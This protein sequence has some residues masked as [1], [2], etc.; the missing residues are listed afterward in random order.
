MRDRIDVAKLKF[1]REKWRLDRADA[2]FTEAN[3]ALALLNSAGAAA[4]LAFMQALVGKA[5]T[6]GEFKA[7]GVIALSLFLIGALSAAGN[8]AFRLGIW[9]EFGELDKRNHEKIISSAWN[10]VI[11][12]GCFTVAAGV[13]VL[14]IVMA[15]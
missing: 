13:A 6:L 10:V 4:M 11:A 9:I 8:A 3:K 5:D 7:F 12:M 1:E 15:L 14:G 2:L